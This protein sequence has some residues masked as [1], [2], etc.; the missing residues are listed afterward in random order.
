MA[1][2]FFTFN[3]NL[4][5]IYVL[6]RTQIVLFFS[7]S[8]FRPETRYPPRRAKTKRRS[9][10]QNPPK[11]RL[12]TRAQTRVRP[13]YARNLPFRHSHSRTRA[14]LRHRSIFFT[15]RYALIRGRQIHLNKQSYNTIADCDHT[16]RTPVFLTNI[17]IISQLS[18]FGGY[19][20]FKKSHL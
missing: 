7:I 9:P 10:Q 19:Q 15:P 4:S 12:Q 3:F 8:Q 13:T 14:H 1:I 20:M 16:I 18:K 5:A 11:N 17:V 2:I 6:K